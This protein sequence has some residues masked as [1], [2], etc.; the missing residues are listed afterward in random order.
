[1]NNFPIVI[2]T[3]P[4]YLANFEA[5]PLSMDSGRYGVCQ[6]NR[7]CHA[8]KADPGQFRNF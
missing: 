4:I 2:M 8:V 1:M 5:H 6:Y 7:V 3:G